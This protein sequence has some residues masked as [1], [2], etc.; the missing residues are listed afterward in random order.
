[1][2]TFKSMQTPAIVLGFNVL[3]LKLRFVTVEFLSYDLERSG[4]I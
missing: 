2:Q 3:Q 4:V 1:M